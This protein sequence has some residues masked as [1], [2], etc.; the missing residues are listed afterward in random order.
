MGKASSCVILC[1]GEVLCYKSAAKKIPPGAFI[2]CADSGYNH[3]EKLS[4]KPDLLVGDFDSIG[5][6]PA[7]I[8]A[9]TLPAEKDYTDTYI[10]A[11]EALRMNFSEVVFI[12]IGGG[13]P[14]HTIANLQTMARLSR[15]G[16]RVSAADGKSE[17]FMLTAPGKLTVPKREGCLF[18]VFAF[19]DICRGVC[20]SGA[21]YALDRYDLSFDDP[22]AVSNEFADTNPVVTLEEG[23][24]LVAV[25]LR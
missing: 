24:M 25:T 16:L 13:R 14:D 11:M 2:I 1:G 9:I 20:I 17:M 21:K 15:A 19:S 3:C 6:I 10:A 12:G 23:T 18:S 5:E 8:P 22:R 7:G 4:V